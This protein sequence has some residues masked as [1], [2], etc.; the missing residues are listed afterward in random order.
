[1]WQRTVKL[2][3]RLINVSTRKQTTQPRLSQS[4]INSLIKGVILKLLCVWILFY[5]AS[6]QSCFSFFFF[7]FKS[8]PGLHLH[9]LAT[10]R[11]HINRGGSGGFVNSLDFYL[12][13][14]KSHGCFY[15]RY[16]LSS[17]WKAVTVKSQ[18]QH[19]QL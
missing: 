13:S 9:C 17:Q 18:S 2:A 6:R 15:F 4:L 5:N 7:F 1:M 19:C 14:L 16:L 8:E 10:I 11:R 3:T 12:A